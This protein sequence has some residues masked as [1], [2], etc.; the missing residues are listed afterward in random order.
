MLAG[1][2]FLKLTIFYVAVTVLVFALGAVVPDIENYLPIGGAKGLLTGPADD[3][4]ES[5]SI[6]ATHVSTL[7]ESIFWMVVAVAGAVLMVL[8]VSWTYMACRDSKDYDQSLIETII[9]LPIAVTSLVVI[10]HNSLALAFSLAGIVGGVRFRH[11]LKSPGDALYILLAIAIGLSAGIGAIE[12]AFVMSL[13]FNYVFLVLWVYDYGAKQGTR[14]YLRDTHKHHK[15]DKH[16][17]DN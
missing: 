1:R 15:R 16:E 11:N 8:P 13:L 4:F 14:R 12:I 17:E 5:V 9:V 3:P 2:L 7:A 10:V 6:G